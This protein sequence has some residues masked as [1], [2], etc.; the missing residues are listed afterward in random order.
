MGCWLFPLASRPGEI[1]A[2]HWSWVRDSN[3]PPA[4]YESAALPPELTQRGAA[5]RPRTGSLPLTRR[6]LFPLS[7]HSVLFDPPGSGGDYRADRTPPNRAPR[8]NNL[9]IARFRLYA[10][11]R[12]FRC[13]SSPSEAG[14]TGFPI[15]PTLYMDYGRAGAGLN[16][17]HCPVSAW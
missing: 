4:V 11:T 16:L 5:F 9:H 2:G 13:S 3:T 7:Y 10:K 6:L 8:R 14:F 15:D 17:V 1:C 12:P